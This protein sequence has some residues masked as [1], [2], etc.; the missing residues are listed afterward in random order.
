VSFQVRQGDVF[1]EAAATLPEGAIEVA[2]DRRGRVILALG[3]HTGHAHAIAARAATLY[4]VPGE[5]DRW[6]VIRP[7][8]TTLETGHG[9]V[10]RHEEHA[11]IVLEPGVYRVR[12]QREY[13]PSAIRTVVD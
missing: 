3:E 7:S 1:I 11:A 4:E 6:L 5:P 9:A 10:L 2:R 12:Q 13:S 8:G